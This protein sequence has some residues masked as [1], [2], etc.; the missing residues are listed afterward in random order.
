MSFARGWSS[1]IFNDFVTL[2]TM[3]PNEKLAVSYAIAQS[4]KL[5][6]FEMRV[7]QVIDNT[8]EYPQKLADTGKVQISQ[9]DIS[10]KVGALFIQRNDVNLHSSLLDMPDFL[11]QEDLFEP[12]YLALREY[13]DIDRRLD[14]LNRR[15]EIVRELLDML[16]TLLENSTAN[17]LEWVIIILILVEVLLQVATN[18]VDTRCF[19][20]CNAPDL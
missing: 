5:E 8:K 20:L 2:G 14:V 13:M 11:W 7:E 19:S 15:L 18:V 9:T 16:T 3:H 17:R 6:V 4:L 10:K 1:K 12:E